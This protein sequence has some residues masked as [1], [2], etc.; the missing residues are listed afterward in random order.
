[1]HQL[2]I[3]LGYDMHAFADGRPLILGG[4]EVPHD[5]GLAGHSDADVVVHALMDALLGAMRIGDIGA[6]FPDT[7]QRYKGACSLDLLERVA[8]IA[9][10][11]GWRLVDADIVLVLQEPRVSPFRDE[12]RAAMAQRLH[13]DA[14]SIGLKATTT[15]GLDA[16][17]RKEGAAAHAVVLMERVHA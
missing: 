2:R 14:D 3:G 6:L 16:I 17:G 1:M 5:R 9:T 4:V 11:S 13:V 12:M 7:D 8:T 10:D 15:E